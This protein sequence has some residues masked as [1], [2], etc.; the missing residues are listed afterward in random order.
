MHYYQ[1]HIGDYATHTRHLTPIE[2][3][4]YRR[5]LDIY[6]LHERPLSD[7]LTTVAR[8]I[9]M[10]EYESEVDL[11]LT[12][13]FDHI[14]GGY[15]NRRADKEIEHY[16]AKVEQAS[17]AGRA[18]AERRT[19]G[20]STDVQPTNNHKP[21]T[22]NHISIDQFETFWKIYPKKVSKENA[23]KAWIKIKPNDDLIIKITKAVKDQKLSERESQ[24]IPHAATWLNNKRWEDEVTTIQKPLMGWK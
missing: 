20:R 11:V 9:N 19:N 22:I 12:E 3:I 8:Q 4:A 2:D 24:F 18:S 21:I 6:Y 23:K 13:F 15:I 10:R 7:C 14:D 1:F 5:L 16:K 17:R